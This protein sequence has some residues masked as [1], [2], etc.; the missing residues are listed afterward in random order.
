[1]PWYPYRPGRDRKDIAEQIRADDHVKRSG[2]STKRAHRISYAVVPF[3]FR[4]LLRHRF[5]ALVPEGM[6]M[7][8]PL[9]LV[10]GGQGFTRAALRQ[11][12]SA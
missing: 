3:H 2:W 4:I 8:S 10:G 1:M 11:F 12:K 6:L 7:A 9:D 5:D